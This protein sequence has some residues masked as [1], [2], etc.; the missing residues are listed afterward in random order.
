MKRRQFKN[1]IIYVL[2]G[3]LSPA[4]NFFL[5][6]LYTKF[7]STEHY[8]IITIST[9]LQSVLGSFIG[10]GVSGAYYRFYFDYETEKERQR[11][12]D[13]CISINIISTVFAAVFPTI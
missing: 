6:P 3:F 7:L 4:L 9:V 8:G 10:I 5:I 2:L 12:L 13:T 11:L 1:S